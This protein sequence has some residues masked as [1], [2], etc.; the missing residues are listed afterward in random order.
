ML[1]ELIWINPI[2]INQFYAY[3]PININQFYAYNPINIY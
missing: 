1:I 2:N 3:N